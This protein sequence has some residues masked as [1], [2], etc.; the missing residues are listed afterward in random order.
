MKSSG[1]YLSAPAALRHF[2]Q[3]EKLKNEVWLKK[4]PSNDDIHRLKHICF[5]R[6]EGCNMGMDR[7]ARSGPKKKKR[8]WVFS[9]EGNLVANPGSELHHFFFYNYST[10][11]EGTCRVMSTAV[12]WLH[13]SCW[14]I[15]CII[16]DRFNDVRFKVVRVEVL[17]Q[18]VGSCLGTRGVRCKGGFVKKTRKD[19]AY[20]GAAPVYLSTSRN[21]H[22]DMNELLMNV[23]LIL[24]HHKSTQC[25]TMTGH[26]HAAWQCGGHPRH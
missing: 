24:S 17:L 21:K 16:H 1:T 3:I 20:D 12:Y 4:K 2:L 6:L 7:N 11:H 19:P 8:S 15:P 13:V 25:Y 10:G 23:R 18:K 22:P 9:R 14:R 5:I 26:R